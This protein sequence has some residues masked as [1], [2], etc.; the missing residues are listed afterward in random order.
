MTYYDVEIYSANIACHATG[1]DSCLAAARAVEKYFPLGEAKNAPWCEE[2]K[3]NPYPQSS[4][5]TYHTFLVRE[6]PAYELVSQGQFSWRKKKGIGRQSQLE[7]LEKLALEGKETWFQLE[8][9]EL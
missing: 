1:L 6:R 3:T 4:S 5:E 9:N 7:Y 2:C 8:I